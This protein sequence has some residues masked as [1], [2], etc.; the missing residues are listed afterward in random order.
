LRGTKVT[1]ARVLVVN[2]LEMTA[3]PRSRAWASPLSTT[4]IL[5][6]ADLGDAR[7]CGGRRIG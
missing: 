5:S 1:I 4:P 6:L 3:E 7:P 2:D